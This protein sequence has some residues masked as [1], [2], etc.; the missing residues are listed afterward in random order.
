MK[1]QI[2]PATRE[3]VQN[4]YVRR[5][6]KKDGQLYNVEF[7]TIPMVKDPTKVKK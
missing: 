4:M 7:E 6:E 1:L 3:I 2:D 5:V